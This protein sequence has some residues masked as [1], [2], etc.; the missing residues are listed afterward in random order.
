MENVNVVLPNL[1]LLKN[2]EELQNLL[3]KKSSLSPSQERIL[4]WSGKFLNGAK[5]NLR[6]PQ[7]QTINTLKNYVSKTIK[8]YKN[9]QLEYNFS[10]GRRKSR[11][12][13]KTRKSKNI[14][15][16]YGD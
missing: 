11:R 10:G 5:I 15:T 2:I 4:T 8:K 16:E 14:H 12:Q 13:R 7:K 6:R 1:K 3:L 9:Q